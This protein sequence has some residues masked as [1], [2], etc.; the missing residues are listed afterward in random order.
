MPVGFWLRRRRRPRNSSESKSQ[1][2]YRIIPK[3]TQG[4]CQN[5]FCTSRIC[6]NHYLGP[7]AVLASKGLEKKAALIQ[8]IKLVKESQIS[9]SE[10]L[11]TPAPLFGEEF[12]KLWKRV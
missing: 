8:A 5:P 4:G 12:S 1:L 9:I 2:T 11:C 7:E 10:E 3:L 6:P